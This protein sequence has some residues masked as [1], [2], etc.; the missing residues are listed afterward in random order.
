MV[1][2]TDGALVGA[3]AIACH[4]PQASF[5]QPDFFQQLQARG[6]FPLQLDFETT[7]HGSLLFGIPAGSL[8]AWNDRM[9]TESFPDRP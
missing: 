5:Q 2:R 3:V 4:E 7:V 6:L 9:M 8:P 1:Q